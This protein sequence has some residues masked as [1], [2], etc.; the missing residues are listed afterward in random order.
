M[1]KFTLDMLI[2][3]F[4]FLIIITSSGSKCVL[5]HS[6]FFFCFF[7]RELIKKLIIKLFKIENNFIDLMKD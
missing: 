7:N 5:E 3:R 4:L 6:K 1:T 2:K